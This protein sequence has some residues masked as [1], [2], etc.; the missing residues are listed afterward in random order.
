M[1]RNTNWVRRQGR[2]AGAG[3]RRRRV[4]AGRTECW[5]R[6]GAGRAGARHGQVRG[7]RAATGAGRA[8][9][10]A[11][12]ARGNRR[13]A[14][15]ATGAGCAR[16][17][18]R[19]ARGTQAQA[20]GAWPGRVAGPAGCAL[21]ALSLFLTRFDSVLFLSQFLDIVREPGS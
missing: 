5:A 4:G 9:Q 15:A 19:G 7:A 1:Y 20:L 21:G 12:G 17:Q 13:G 2:W 18:A 11:R 16:Q 10:Q 6:M 3:R 14:R 8:R